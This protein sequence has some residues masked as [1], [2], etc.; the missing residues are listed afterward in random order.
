MVEDKD[1][2]RRWRDYETS[3]GKRPVRDFLRGLTDEDAAAVLA[4][5]RDVREKGNSAGRHLRGEIW[6]VRAD[7]D[8]VIYRVLYASVGSKSRILLGLDGFKKKTQKTPQ[9]KIAL[10]E[11]RLKDWLDRG[12][13]KR[14]KN[15]K[16]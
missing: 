6:E 12:K 16:P 9:T 14:K 4:A 13:R 8:K 2:R 3:A 11:R 1:V 15:K 7:G 10:A 5:M